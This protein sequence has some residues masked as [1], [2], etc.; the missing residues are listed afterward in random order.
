MN[1][2][3]REK[4]KEAVRALIN[5]ALLEAAVLIA[6]VAYYL[7]TGE[8]M[9]LIAGV[10]GSSLLFGPLFFRWFREHGAVMRRKDSGAP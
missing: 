6:V 7:K 3:D 8:L 10:I 1:G 9:H 5:I 4:R 2:I